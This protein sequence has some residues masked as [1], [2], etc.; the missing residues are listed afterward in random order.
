MT[1]RANA[2]ELSGRMRLES[3]SFHREVLQGSG[4]DPAAKS[5]FVGSVVAGSSKTIAKVV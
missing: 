3:R 4:S 2:A 5:I 1:Q